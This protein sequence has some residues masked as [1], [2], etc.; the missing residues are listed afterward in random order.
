[1]NDLDL[2]RGLRDSDAQPPTPEARAAARRALLEEA[3]RA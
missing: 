3:T 1:M 2:L